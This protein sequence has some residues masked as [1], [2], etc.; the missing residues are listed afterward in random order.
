MIIVM[1]LQ[2]INLEE[3]GIV[4]HIRIAFATTIVALCALLY[5]TY[6][7]CANGP[8]KDDRVKVKAQ[9]QFGNEVAPATEC[10]V[11]EYDQG[12]IMDLVKQVCIGAAVCSG[13]HYKWEYAVPLVMQCIMTPMT[14]FESPVIQIHVLGKAAEGD[15]SRPFADAKGPFTMEAPK[16][17]EERAEQRKKDQETAERQ[18]KE[19][20]NA[21]KKEEKREAKKNK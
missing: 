18:L 9:E 1:G 14:V 17:E 11:A 10:S 7:K 16:T 15:L 8:Q 20:K 12:K 4:P 2:K 13:I 3:M 6:N 5:H 21:E 19:L